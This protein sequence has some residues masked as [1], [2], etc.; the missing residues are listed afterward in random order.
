MYCVLQALGKVSAAP[1][2]PAPTRRLIYRGFPRGHA[3]ILLHSGSKATG[4]EAT[5]QSYLFSSM[6]TRKLRPGREVVPHMAW[7]RRGLR[8]AGPP[9]SVSGT[10]F[11]GTLGCSATFKALPG[12][13]L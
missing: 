5:A 6:H 12:S 1:L 2:L 10:L 9:D 4:E 7:L 3:S 11:P 13:Q 8:P